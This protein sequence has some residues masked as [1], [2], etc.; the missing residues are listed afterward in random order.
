MCD[1]VIVGTVAASTTPQT[2]GAD[3]LFVVIGVLSAFIAIG[4]AVAVVV[5]ALVVAVFVRKMK[6]CRTAGM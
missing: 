5:I 1:C 3:D 6:R 2:S 4:L